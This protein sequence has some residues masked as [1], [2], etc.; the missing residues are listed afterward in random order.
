MTVVLRLCTTE[1]VKMKKLES[2]KETPF[3]YATFRL[4]EGKSP[5]LMCKAPS[6]LKRM[7]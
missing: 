1:C 2:S 6:H 4:S 7:P 5:V 3:L